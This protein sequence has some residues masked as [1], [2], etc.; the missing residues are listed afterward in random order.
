[1]KEARISANDAICEKICDLNN[2][3]KLPVGEFIGSLI[4]VLGFV[5]EGCPS[6]IR[7]PIVKVLIGRLQAVADGLPSQGD[8]IIRMH[9]ADEKQPQ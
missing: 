5:L 8:N 7:Q 9:V 4:A 1:M 2:K 3:E 6:E